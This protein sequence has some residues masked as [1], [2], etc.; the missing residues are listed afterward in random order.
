MITN[1]ISRH[2][3]LWAVAGLMIASLVLTLAPGTPAQATKK[4]KGKDDAPKKEAKVEPPPA[5]FPKRIDLINAEFGGAQHVAFI[6]EQITKMWKENKTY[7]SERCTD[8]E[9]I[10][11]ASL[12]IIGR[13]PTVEEINRFMDPKKHPPEKRRSWLINA[14]LDGPEYGEGREYAQN[15]A[16]S[17]DRASHD[18]NGFG[19]ALPSPDERL[20]LHPAQGEREEWARLVEDRP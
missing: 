17:L 6:D 14:M 4:T 1:R 15:F 3:W 11:R 10:R 13:I 7:P 9:F 8:Y 18:A 5:T 19:Q 12:D 16:N 20:A 2:V